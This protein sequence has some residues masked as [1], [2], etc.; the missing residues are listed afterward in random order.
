V[1]NEGEMPNALWENA[2]ARMQRR[3]TDSALSNLNGFPQVA[4]PQTGSWATVAEG[5]W[6]GGFWVGLLWLAH[7]QSGDDRLRH[8][9]EHWAERLRP[10]IHSQ[11]VF[12]GFLFYYGAALADIL[13]DNPIGREL[14]LLGAQQ[15]ATLYDSRARLIP[16]GTQAAK[17]QEAQLRETNID[18]LA[19]TALLVW[20]ATRSGD[21]TLREIARAHA[22]RHIELCIRDDGSVHQSA[23]FDPSTG[24]LTARF[25][26]KGCSDESTWARAQAWAMLGYALTAKWIPDEPRFLEVAKLVSDWW[27]QQVPGDGVAYWDFSDPQIPSVP[28]DSSATAIALASL[29]KL[30][31]LT[32]GND[33]ARYRTAAEQTAET[34][35]RKYL[36]PVTERD[37]RPPGIL[38]EGCF[39]GRTGQATNNELIWGDYF[40]FE[41]LLVLNGIL[42][43]LAI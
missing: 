15:L 7:Y 43:P 19:L 24:N 39:N 33:R 37:K 40:L 3:T 6:T 28:R 26:H 8:Q 42:D 23:R 25:T 34:L 10:R 17:A 2:L 22:A 4:D 30:S 13:L 16:I 12:R 21:G 38:T 27:I 1:E 41:A 29:L 14:G 9:A 11:T 20:A 18:G 5:D 36:T 31:A 32:T 35:V